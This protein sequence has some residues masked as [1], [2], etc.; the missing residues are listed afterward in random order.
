MVFGLIPE[1]RGEE[2]R[3]EK[4]D[5]STDPLSS[6]PPFPW[7]HD[8]FERWGWLRGSSLLRCRGAAAVTT[9]AGGGGGGGEA[10]TK[11]MSTTVRPDTDFPPPERER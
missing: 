7:R 4:E 9:T 8:S 6:L 10:T 5:L 11:Q 1:R 2:R 3:G